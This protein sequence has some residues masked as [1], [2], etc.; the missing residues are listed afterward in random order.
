MEQASPVLQFFFIAVTLLAV[1]LLYRASGRSILLLVVLTAWTLIQLLI[2]Q[3]DFFARGSTQ[4]ARFLLLV[5]PAPAGILV[6]FLSKRGRRFIDNFN[7]GQLTLLHSIRVPVEIILYVLF[8]AR[9]VPE[10]MTFEG[11]NFDILAG[12]S[13]PLVWYLGYA[14]KKLPVPVLITWNILCLALL[15]NIVVIA[16]LSAPSPFQ[17]FGFDQPNIAVVHFPFNWLPSVVVPIVL[18]AHLATLRQLLRAKNRPV[19]GVISG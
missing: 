5:P 18:L 8:T 3:T 6:L 7:A 17:Q 10:I 19:P 9:T 16:L 2:G 4:P 13:A 1:V 15:V 12:L 14:R 11:R